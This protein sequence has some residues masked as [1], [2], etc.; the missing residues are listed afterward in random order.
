MRGLALAAALGA[1]LDVGLVGGTRSG[2]SGNAIYRRSPSKAN[3]TIVQLFE[4]P[5]TSVATE[6]TQYLAPFG[7]GYVQVSPASEHITGTEWWTDYQPVSYIL[8]S[9]RGTQAEFE[10]MVSTCNAAGVGVI[11]DAVFN[12]MS[13]TTSST[14][15]G[16]AG[17]SYSKYNY[18][19]VP[20]TASQFHYCNGA[21]GAA[22]ISDYTNATNV[23]FCEASLEGLADLAQE[24]ASVRKSIAAY[25]QVLLNAGVAG[26]RIDA[27]KNMPPSNIS[28]IFSLLEGSFYDTQEVGYGEGN[29]ALVEPPAYVGNGDVIEFRVPSS[30]YT[31]FT[32]NEGIANMVTPTPMGSAWGFLASDNANAIMANQDSERT[33]GESLNYTAAN[34]AYTLGAIFLLAFN[35]GTPTVYSGFNFT[36]YDQGKLEWKR[37]LCKMILMRCRCSPEFVRVHQRADVLLQWLALYASLLC[38]VRDMLIYLPGEHRWPAIANMVGFH[39]AVGSSA[40]TNIQEGTNQQIAFGR[41]SIGF[42]AINNEPSPWTNTFTTSLPAGTYCDAIHD[43]NTSPSVCAGTTYTVS[44]G[45]F[46]ATIGAYDAIALY[47][48]KDVS[49]GSG[50]TSGNV[51]ATVKITFNVQVTTVVG[52]QVYLTGS[53]AELN[54]WSTSSDLALS[55]ADYTSSDPLWFV[56]VAIPE[57]TSFQYKFYYTE[58]GAV[59]WEADPNRSYTTGTAAATINDVWQS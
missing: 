12:H 8:T 22:G 48:N 34:N 27:A 21:N 55:A 16:F 32:T 29:S 23:W 13:G 17:S 31:Y 7:Y 11:V 58:N 24:Q 18:P 40:L 53:I 9:K 2:F 52:Q 50:S 47:V 26:F 6:C 45:A 20:Y 41:G 35:Y 42:V 4:W 19:A 3:N 46:S 49:I 59:T 30:I 1:V 37:W 38:L 10:S 51:P 15:T 43:T 5:W 39:N 28:A 14:N 56:T 54:D 25:L 44:G 57:N 33:P 36:N